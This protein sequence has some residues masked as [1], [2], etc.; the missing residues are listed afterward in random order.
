M[1]I[2]LVLRCIDISIPSQNVFNGKCY[3]ALDCSVL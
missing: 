3:L 1:Y 2:L